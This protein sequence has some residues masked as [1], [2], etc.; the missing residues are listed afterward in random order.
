MQNASV[1]IKAI[2]LISKRVLT[3]KTYTTASAHH[4]SPIT[5]QNIKEGIR[6][7]RWPG[8]LEF[9]HDKPPVVIDGAHNPGAARV[10]ARTLKKDF[11]KN[12]KKII[13]ILGIMDDKDIKGIMEPLLPVASEIILTA[14]AYSRSAAPE[15]LAGIARSLGFSNLRVCPTVKDAV[16]M[17]MRLAEDPSFA[18]DC[19]SLILVSGSFY[20]I[21]EAKEAFGKKGVLS[22]L[23]E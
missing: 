10:L 19:Q 8:R 1:A 12:Y 7:V 2:E 18:S 15:K 4:L 23:R 21:G 9:I 13:I 5:Q 16:D 20:T 11:L 3:P 6:N 17:A 22:R 14:P